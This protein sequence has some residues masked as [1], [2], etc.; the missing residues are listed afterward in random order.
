MLF[1]FFSYLVAKETF[2][3]LDFDLTVKFQDNLPR[4]VDFPFST[5]S[6]LGSAE[7]SLSIWLFLS[8]LLFFK[9]YW[10][11]FFSMGL[12]PLALI[13]EIFGKTFIYHPGPPYLFYR[14]VIKF[15]FPSHFIQANYS[16]PSGH[17]TRTAFL[18]AF[19]MVFFYYKTS[20]KY[21]VLIQSVLSGL[22]ILMFISRIYL[23]EHW[24]SDVIGGALIGVSF[25]IIPAIF[26]V[27]SK[28][29]IRELIN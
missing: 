27:R 29:E 12:L 17:M 3:K 15:D 25:G 24:T 8:G 1:V 20:F 7:I 16:Y 13:L 14:G 5:L 28:K 2:T 26:T 18:I 10:L 21:Q 9:R 11:S 4:R 6:V 22:L 23:G 19:L